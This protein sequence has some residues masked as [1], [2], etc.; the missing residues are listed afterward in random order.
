MYRGRGC[1]SGAHLDCLAV[2]D[3][4][5]VWLSGDRVGKLFESGRGRGYKI[6]LG[7]GHGSMQEVPFSICRSKVLVGAIPSVE[8]GEAGSS[9]L[10]RPMSIKLKIA[11]FERHYMYLQLHESRL[12]SRDWCFVYRLGEL[13]W[14]SGGLVPE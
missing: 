14:Q 11:I 6:F 3:R 7:F 5:K 12:V 1:V 10:S 8:T 9:K 4:R 2:P 13:S